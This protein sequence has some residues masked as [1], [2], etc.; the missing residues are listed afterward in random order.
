MRAARWNAVWERGGLWRVVLRWRIG[1]DPGEFAEPCAL[2]LLKPG[3]T[4][5]SVDPIVVTVPGVLTNSN[6][7]L[8]LTRSASETAAMA[9]GDYTHRL[10][11]HDPV[12][13]DS[14]ILA[15]GWVRVTDEVPTP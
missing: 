15:R 3:S 4:W 7:D 11:V 9:A 14:R 8:V 5:D 6:R 13:D 2:E 10:V 1:A 12:A